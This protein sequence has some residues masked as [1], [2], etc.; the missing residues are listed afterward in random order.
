MKIL[1]LTNHD[2]RPLLKGTSLVG[3]FCIILLAECFSAAESKPEPV[4]F[5]QGDFSSD[6]DERNCCKGWD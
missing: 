2:L 6:R 5:S 3:I 4:N 1:L